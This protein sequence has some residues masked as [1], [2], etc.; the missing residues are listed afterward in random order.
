MM[1]TLTHGDILQVP[2]SPRPPKKTP[3]ILYNLQGKTERGYKK[4]GAKMSVC[5]TQKKCHPFLFDARVFVCETIVS[6]FSYPR[7]AGCF[8]K[9]K[10]NFLQGAEAAELYLS[11]GTTPEKAH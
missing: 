6:V 5:H 8:W 2:L 11:H 7:S 1:F 4:Y 10:D 9:C 3:C